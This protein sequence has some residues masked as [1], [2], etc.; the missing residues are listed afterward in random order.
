MNNRK[1]RRIVIVGGGTAGWITASGLAALLPT[2]DYAITLIESDQIGTVG[3]GEATIPP[4]RLFNSELGIDEAEFMRETGAT[5]KLGIQFHNWRRKGQHYFHPFGQHGRKI[6]MVPF[7]QYWLRTRQSGDCADL[8]EFSLGEVMARSNKFM[9]NNADPKSVLSTMAYAYHLDAGLYA[10][11]LR[12]YAEKKGVTRIE[13]KVID[14]KLR[15][16][17][18]YIQSLQLESS[19]IIEGDLF[20]DCSGFRGLLIE[21]A[22]KT[23]YEDWSH[24]LPCDRAIAVPSERVG[25]TRP[26]T[27][28]IAHAAGWQWR[29]PL[30]H[31]TGNGH[32]FCSKYMSEDEAT[33]TLLGNLEGKPLA[34]PR[35]LP[36]TTGRRKKFWNK[37]CVAI[38]LS[39]GFMEPLEST[40]IHLIQE[41]VAQLLRLFPGEEFNQAEIDQFNEITGRD[42]DRIRDF[43]ILHYHVNE[44]PED[45]WRLC[46]NMDI[47]ES[48]YQRIAL[49][50]NRG[51][52]FIEDENLFKIDSW[53][54][55]LT[56]QG[57]TPSAYDPVADRQDAKKV[58]RFLDDIH[59]S[60]IK[61]TD[62]M[63]SHDDFIDRHCKAAFGRA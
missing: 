39:A 5:F 56:G 29:I 12:K 47:P 43:L 34:E 38:G 18:G 53:L 63:P 61:A 62:A 1:I 26:Y 41:S 50:K 55:V 42:Y 30:Q 60:F 54:A 9:P 48:L 27:M 16:A 58:A 14:V 24:F 37:N 36:F 13:G 10:K 23:G 22:L 33:S 46:Q 59:Q 20:I 2:G 32:V 25:A 17:D 57:V 51:R 7:H 49:F 8:Q 52:L 11:F 28:S 21:E 19:R 15:E 45:F 3:V 31:R 40:S 44:R 35:M 6:D 4:L